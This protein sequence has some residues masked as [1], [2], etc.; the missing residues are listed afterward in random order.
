MHV[1]CQVV[2]LLIPNQYWTLIINGLQTLNLIV[3]MLWTHS[4]T[5]DCKKFRQSHSGIAIQCPTTEKPAPG[6]AAPPPAFSPFSSTT[7]QFVTQIAISVGARSPFSP[8]ARTPAGT[9]QG[10]CRRTRP[11]SNSIGHANYIGP[12]MA[13]HID[14]SIIAV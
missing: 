4:R 2:K 7:I 1:S 10:K 13:D 12:K 8:S 9:K 11:R 6:P 14:K 5:A 3:A